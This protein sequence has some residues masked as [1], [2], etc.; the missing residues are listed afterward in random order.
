MMDIVGADMRKYLES[1]RWMTFSADLSKATS[2]EIWILLGEAA[3]K[4][5]HLAQSPLKPALATELMKVALVKGAV[6]TTAIEG[7]TLTEDQVRRIVE[8][9]LK[10]P[11]SQAYLK[12]EVEN[13]IRAC[14]QVAEELHNGSIPPLT[15]ERMKHWNKLLL[16]GLNLDPEIIP[17]EIR[18]HSVTVGRYLGA[19]AEDCAYLLDKLS[20]WVPTLAESAGDN[21]NLKMPFAIIQA[22]LAHLYMAWIHPFG[23]GNGRTARMI[24]FQL[25]VQA[26]VPSVGAHLLS[27]HY[28]KTRSEYYRQLDYASRSGGDIVAFIKYAT[29]GL[30]DG[31]RE[32]IEQVNEQQIDL[33]W[34][35]FI[36]EQIFHE[37]SA[38]NERRF[39]LLKA[40]TKSKSAI[41]MH[42]LL[43]RY[44]ALAKEYAGKTTK[45]ITRD[46]NALISLDLVS[47][48]EK[49][50]RARIERIHAFLPARS[51]S[52]KE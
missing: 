1:H 45:S 14:N 38:C 36:H 13:V 43:E 32:Q 17:G 35:D 19:P 34:K 2:S 3:S 52:G 44:P 37:P 27:N 10:L 51:L 20:E 6:A 24:E 8:G 41:K 21:E 5:E 23:D 48:T 16:E 47:K 15:V 18:Q 29:T 33:A 11:P 7:N 9:E 39:R 49:G 42:D 25:L 31:L 26:G 12:Q 30:V 22:V 46:I 40:L 28:N 4:I 50:F